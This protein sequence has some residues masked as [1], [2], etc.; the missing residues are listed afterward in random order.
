M[1]VRLQIT[2]PAP[3]DILD[4]YGAG[5]LGRV[6]RSTTEAGVYAEV[7]TFPVD[8]K[9]LYEIW[10]TTGLTTS[11]YKVRYS[12][13]D[14]PTPATNFSTYGDPFTPGQPET[15]ASLDDLLLSLPDHATDT[16]FLADAQQRL[17]EAARDID[18][19]VGY[20]ALRTPY[21]GT[22]ERV[23]DSD[24]G[25]R[26][27]IHEGIAQL[28]KVEILDARGGDW[29]EIDSGDYYLEAEPGVLTPRPGEPYYH[30]VMA[31]L[32]TYPSW[33]SFRQAVR[34]TLA[35]GFATVHPTWREANVA[36][37][38]QRSSAGASLPGSMTGPEGFRTAMPNLWPRSV[39]D[40]VRRES[41]RHWCSF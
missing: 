33:P 31:D 21:T 29:I 34:L 8:E 40:L 3:D 13:T 22:E 14:T 28:D 38:R 1:A 9:L 20:S 2:V 10:D 37:A 25:G 23:F 30:I 32:A 4:G 7:L 18:A 17:I 41:Q 15:Y 16:K 6:E 19:E 24:G 12:G 5:A 26:L 11:W 35:T 36:L 27:H 39:Y